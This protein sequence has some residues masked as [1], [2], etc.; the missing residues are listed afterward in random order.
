MPSPFSNNICAVLAFENSMV[1]IE[2]QSSWLLSRAACL[3]PNEQECMHF[4]QLPAAW[5]TA[6]A[7]FI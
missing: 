7:F 4:A 6:V 5:D 2:F 1:H 3:L